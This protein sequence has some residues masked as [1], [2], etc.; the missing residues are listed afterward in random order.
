[1]EKDEQVFQFNP[2]TDDVHCVAGLL[3]VGCHEHF[4]TWAYLI[5]D[6]P[7]R[8]PGTYLQSEPGRTLAI[9]PGSRY[10]DSLNVPFLHLRNSDRSSFGESYGV[11]SSQDSST[12]TYPP[13]N[14]QGTPRAS[15]QNHSLSGTK[16]DGC[17]KP[18]CRFWASCPWGRTTP[19]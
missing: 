1:M 16:P 11:S 12:S 19:A 7:T 3:K 5:L 13:S 4:L 9:Y 17:E 14:A 15:W 10:S 8:T 6:V 18:G 2:M